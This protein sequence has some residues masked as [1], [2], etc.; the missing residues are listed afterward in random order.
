MVVMC[1][2]LAQINIMARMNCDTIYI[3]TYNGGD[4]FDNF[5]IT[6]GCTHEFHDINCVLKS[7][8]HNCTDGIDQIL[9]NGIIKYDK[10]KNTFFLF[11]MVKEL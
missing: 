4:L 2:K 7:N 8:L 10:N 9:R 5:S 11:L 1:H 3:T 6:Y